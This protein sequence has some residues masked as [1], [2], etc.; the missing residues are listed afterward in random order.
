MRTST[1]GG[2]LIRDKFP[3]AFVGMLAGVVAFLDCAALLVAAYLVNASY[4]A[5]ATP[6]ESGGGTRNLLVVAALLASALL[7]DKR[8]GSLARRAR[9]F[10][11]VRYYLT[12]FSLFVCGV[13]VIG[14]A[15][16]ALH[17]IPPL[18]V[19]LWL[20]LIFV[21]TASAR[22]VLRSGVRGATRNGALEDVVA[23]VGAGSL[24]DRLTRDLRNAQ[25]GSMQ[26][27]GVFDDDVASALSGRS[28]VSGTIDDLIHL[29][30]TRHLDWIFL[31]LPCV[32]E[33]RLAAVVRRLKALSVPIALCPWNVGLGTPY[34]VIDYVGGALPVTVLVGHPAKRWRALIQSSCQSLPRWVATLLLLQLSLA[35][36]A[37]QRARESLHAVMTGSG[38]LRCELDAYDL[39]SF[40]DAAKSFGQSRYGFVVTPNVDHLIRLHEDARFRELYAAAR[41]VLLDSRF[42][43]KL[44]RATTGRVLP[45][46][47]GSDLTAKL[48]A[49]VIAPGDRI[50]V[51][52][53][54]ERQAAELR[55]RHALTNLVQFSP[56]MGFIRDPRAVEKCLRFVEAHSPFRFCLLAVGAPQQE[57]L[58]E[59]L[60]VRNVARGLA[61]CVG[62]SIDFITGTQRRAPRWLQHAGL[63]WLFRL[64]QNPARMA[65]RYLVRGP[66]VFGLLRK[67]TFVLRVQS[68]ELV[69][70][71]A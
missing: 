35:V 60:R 41:Y 55:K 8:L 71:A 32:D 46:C 68:A 58:A 18:A 31:N 25:G 45:V 10:G 44:L 28:A 30:K 56:P 29:G 53:G 1:S 12:R 21:L 51:I 11:P 67:T 13:V 14:G 9:D 70:Q 4:S 52:G 22:A 19:V 43:A 57:V 54:N 59:R 36:A 50:V 3:P 38:G 20:A 5:W 62:A 27:L 61:L 47:T 69:K 63:E 24:A 15:S 2:H 49:E 39:A 66:R 40:S 6:L 65:M 16:G 48:F 26:I 7:Y 33:R 23:I 37:W 17:A 64:A 34:E 42:L